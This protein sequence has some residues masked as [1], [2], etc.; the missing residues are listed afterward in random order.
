MITNFAPENIGNC[1]LDYRAPHSRRPQFGYSAPWQTQIFFYTS[2][3]ME[4]SIFL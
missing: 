3:V 2:F 1:L 4:N